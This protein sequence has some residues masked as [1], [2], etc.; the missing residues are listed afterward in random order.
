VGGVAGLAFGIVAAHGPSA[1]TWSAVGDLAGATA[2]LGTLAVA[3]GAVYAAFQ[4]VRQARELR[5]EQARPY[6]AVFMEPSTRS[7][8]VIDLVI[9]NFGSTAAHTT[10][11]LG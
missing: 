3:I 11:A 1:Q 2:A 5:E 6:V 7:P 9:R 8:R 4:Q 10:S